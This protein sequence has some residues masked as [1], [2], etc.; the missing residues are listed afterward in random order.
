MT[1]VRTPVVGSE[2]GPAAGARMCGGDAAPSLAEGIQFLGEYRGSGTVQS[3]HLLRRRDGGVVAVSRLLYLVASAV[4][5]RQTLDE[6]AARVTPQVGRTVSAG[7]V[8]YLVEQKLRPLGVMEGTPGRSRAGTRP[9]LS[10][11]GRRAVV[12]D[13][14]VRWISGKLCFLFIPVVVGAVLAAFAAMDTVLLA[15]WGPASALEEVLHQ[16]SVLVVICLLT[17]VAACFHEVGH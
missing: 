5:G 17:I 3:Q 11:S 16:P 6:I 1:A 2:Q 7:N 10:L 4:D 12:P 13:R 9:I 15:G 14:C 8:A